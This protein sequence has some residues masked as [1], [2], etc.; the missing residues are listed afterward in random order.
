MRRTAPRV[1]PTFSRATV[2]AEKL[3][4]IVHL[5]MANSRMKDYFDLRA[6]VSE[7]E[8]KGDVLAEAIRATFARRRTALPTEVPVG[9]SDAF[10]ADPAKRNQ[11]QGFV[12]RNRLDAPSLGEVVAELRS[13]FAPVLLV[14]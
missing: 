3:E 4:A 6:L 7:G 5:G 8:L 2:V 13:F 1:M 12:R 14:R 10:A 9:L 11:W